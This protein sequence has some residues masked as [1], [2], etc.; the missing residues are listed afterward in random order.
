MVGLRTHVL[1][2]WTV[3]TCVEPVVTIQNVGP[4][5][6]FSFSTDAINLDQ[7]FML[8]KRFCQMDLQK[9]VLSKIF[10]K[11]DTKF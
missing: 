11:S 10:F 7:S 5:R 2:K 9:T 4:A 1:S 6:Y 8:L 3:T